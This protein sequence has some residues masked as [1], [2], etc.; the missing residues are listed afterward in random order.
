MVEERRGG[1]LQSLSAA[2]ILP[3]DMDSKY[4]MEVP[5]NFHEDMRYDQFQNVP[6]SYSHGS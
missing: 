4:W 1:V 5:T 6:I 2:D 3:L